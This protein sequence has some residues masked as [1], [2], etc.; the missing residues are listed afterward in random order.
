M[1]G[2]FDA[3]G[4]LKTY[5]SILETKR[6]TVQLMSKPLTDPST[7]VVRTI[8][9][10]TPDQILVQGHF[11]SSALF[12]MHMRGGR[13]FPGRAEVEW[14]IYGSRGEIKVIAGGPA[15]QVGYPETKILLHRD[16]EGKGGEVEEVKWTKDEWEDLPQAAQNVARLYEAFAD[17]RKSEYKDFGEAL[18]LHQFVDEVFAMQKEDV[19]RKARY[20]RT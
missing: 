12:T 10:H 7:E 13:A 4:P 1:A 17:G 8:E 20:Y 11:E 15:L 16:P 19:E 6:K 14:S 5:T 9:R 2:I 3:L 18:I